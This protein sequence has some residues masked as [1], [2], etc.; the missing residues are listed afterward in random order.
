[1]KIISLDGRMM[2]TRS[3]AYDYM[4]RV[5]QF[6]DYFGKNLDALADCL[7][8]LNEEAIVIFIN[9]HDMLEALEGYGEKIL[10]VFRDVSAEGGT[11]TFIEK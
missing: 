1:M 2:L 4:N 5:F 11:F 8:E 9:R 7:S 10:D 3:S 6:P